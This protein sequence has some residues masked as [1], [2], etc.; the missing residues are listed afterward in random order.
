MK[1]DHELSQILQARLRQV[2]EARN[3][4]IRELAN[5][6]QLSVSQLY[7]L[8]KGERPRVAAL[9][10]ARLAQALDTSLDFLLGLREDE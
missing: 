7:R 3:L 8:E 6:A 4:S 2:R 1:S 10:L 9:T 5:R